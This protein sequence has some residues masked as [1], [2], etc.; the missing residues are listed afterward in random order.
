MSQYVIDDALVGFGISFYKVKIICKWS[1]D[2]LSSIEIIAKFYFRFDE[3]N[4]RVEYN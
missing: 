2:I 3:L 4:E 1:T